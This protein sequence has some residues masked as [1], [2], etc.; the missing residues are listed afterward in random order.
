MHL[1]DRVAEVIGLKIESQSTPVVVQFPSDAVGYPARPEQVE[2]LHN[3]VQEQMHLVETMP[4]HLEN[5]D[6]QLEG[7]H[8]TL[9]AIEQRL[10]ALDAELKRPAA[11]ERR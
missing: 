7:I 6:D 9:I 11:G 4:G 5:I 1:A 3:L 8:A 2:A 10:E